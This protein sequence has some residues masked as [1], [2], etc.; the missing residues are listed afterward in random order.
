[1]PS[2]V[3]AGYYI[4]FSKLGGN[5]CIGVNGSNQLC[6][7]PFD[8]TTNVNTWIV[9]PIPGSTG[10][11]LEHQA[12]GLSARFASD[13]ITLFDFSADPNNMEFTMVCDDVGDGYTAIN[14]HDRSRVFDDRASR[15]DGTIIPFP[16]NGGDN[17]RWRFVSTA[18]LANPS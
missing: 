15:S 1:M 4:I 6:L 9:N 11:I 12:T 8:K 14:N 5:R 16:W 7:K 10:Y 17:Q 13:P 2:P 18:V 3:F